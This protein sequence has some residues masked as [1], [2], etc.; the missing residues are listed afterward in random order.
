VSKIGVRWTQNKQ[1]WLGGGALVAV[2]VVLIGWFLVIEPQLSAASSTTDLTQSIQTQNL[3]LEASNTKL[4]VQ[5]DAIATL[6]ADLA[7]ALAELPSDGGLAEFTRQI[8]AQA[9]AASVVL[10]SVVV[11]AGTP[12]AA[13]TA[14]AGSTE[15]GSTDTGSGAA[16]TTDT[17]ESA[18]SGTSTSAGSGTAADMVEMTITVSTTGLGG[19]NVAFLRAVGVT[20]PRR[21]LVTASQLAPADSSDAGISGT[22]TLTLTLTIFSAPLPPADQ[23]ALKKLVSGG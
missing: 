10:N 7:A 23:A 5:N 15:P 19:D 9:T 2:L 8:S 21:A 11:G 6:R 17:A 22:S 13:P 16:G 20:G 14:D 3:V 1:L 18:D 4:K 12:V